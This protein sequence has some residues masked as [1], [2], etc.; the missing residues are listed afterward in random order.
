MCIAGFSPRKA[1]FSIYILGG[2]AG[3]AD[4][5]KKL[6]KHKAGKGCLYV[7]RLSDIDLEVLEKLVT[8]S[9]KSVK[10]KWS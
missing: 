10:E 8:R 3:Q 6:G 4:L 9:V 2:L 5:M 1:A 7:N